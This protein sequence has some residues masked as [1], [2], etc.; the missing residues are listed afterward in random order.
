MCVD[1]Q[2]PGIGNYASVDNVE[3]NQSFKHNDWGVLP[4]LL[5]HD[6]GE[7][8]STYVARFIRLRFSVLG[9]YDGEV[10]WL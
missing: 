3:W 8:R 10:W 4:L 7:T 5:C 9:E 1:T 6:G 2:Y